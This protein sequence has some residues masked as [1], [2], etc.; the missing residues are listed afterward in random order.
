MS[1]SIRKSNPKARIISF[2]RSQPQASD[3]YEGN[4]VLTASISFSANTILKIKEER[5]KFSK[6]CVEN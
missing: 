4:I 3:Y 5:K 2:C 6:I 1:V